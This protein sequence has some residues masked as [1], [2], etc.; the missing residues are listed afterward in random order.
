MA[1]I[2]GTSHFWTK[3]PGSGVFLMLC[4]SDNPDEEGRPPELG[5]EPVDTC[6]RCLEMH[7]FDNRRIVVGELPRFEIVFVPEI[8]I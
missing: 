7:H 6:E 4:T 3:Q 1:A 5:R 8:Y 2:D